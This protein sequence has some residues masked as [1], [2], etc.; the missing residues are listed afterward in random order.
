MSSQQLTY[1][2]RMIPGSTS[3]TRTGMIPRP[4]PRVSKLT[5]RLLRNTP[6]N[7]PV[8]FF[9]RNKP[10]VV[11]GRNQVKHSHHLPL[12]LRYRSDEADIPEPMERDHPKG[13]TRMEPPPH[14][15]SI[16]RRN[17][18][19]RSWQYEF[20]NHPPSTLIYQS[21]RC[22]IGSESSE[23]SIGGGGLYGQ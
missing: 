15:P 11:I 16:R 2:N 17:R 19:P 14:P 4:T 20:L 3:P 22:G 21:T 12:L 1:L 8:L 9:Y 5:F 7:Q 6:R 10:C 23:G 18:I 13:F